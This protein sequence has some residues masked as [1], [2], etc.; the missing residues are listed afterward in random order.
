[1]HINIKNNVIKTCIV[2]PLY[3]NELSNYEEIAI[4]RLIFVFKDLYP[5]FLAIP[6]SLVIT[7][8]V[9]KNNNFLFKRF[10]D[11]YFVSISSYNKLMLSINFYKQF[12]DFDYML[13]YQTDCY[14]FK[15]DLEYWVNKKYDY[16]GAPWFWE[17]FFE[18]KKLIKKI[19][20]VGNG[21][22]SLRKIATHLSILE[23]DKKIKFSLKTFLVIKRFKHLNF[24]KAVWDYF[25]Y[26]LTDLFTLKSKTA[27][28]FIEDTDV[29]E[30]VFWSIVSKKYNAN[31]YVPTVEEAANFCFEKN[32]EI[33]FGMNKK[34]LPFACHAWQR[35]GLDFY[36][37]FFHKDGFKI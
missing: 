23:S 18:N 28:S 27:L 8:T 3:K 19:F 32:P 34:E 20:Q 24:F 7:N 14:V 12:D 25:Q 29:V 31:F 22:F 21:G 37:P 35:Y 11:S 26:R 16:I 4:K 6:K 30:D 13:I 9:L 1:M 10:D 15:N 5:V 33:L 17:S 2:V 36:K